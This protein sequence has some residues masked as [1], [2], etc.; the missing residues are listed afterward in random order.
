MVKGLVDKDK[1]EEMGEHWR[2]VSFSEI[3]STMRK[4]DGF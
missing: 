3:D 2:K 1:A 4:K